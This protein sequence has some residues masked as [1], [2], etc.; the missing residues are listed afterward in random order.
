[1]RPRDYARKGRWSGVG[2][3]ACACGRFAGGKKS[4]FH[5]AVPRDQRHGQMATVIAPVVVKSRQIRLGRKGQE[6]S[7]DPAG[8]GGETLDKGGSHG[9]RGSGAGARRKTAE[10]GSKVPARSDFLVIIGET[11]GLQNSVLSPNSLIQPRADSRLILI[12]FFRFR[13]APSPQRPDFQAY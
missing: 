9:L 5:L 8:R 3:R 2:I 6:S 1:M 12:L 13:D 11:P 4:E 10:P 7:D